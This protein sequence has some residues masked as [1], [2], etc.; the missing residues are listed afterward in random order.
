MDAERGDRKTLLSAWAALT[1][2]NSPNAK[3]LLAAMT[4]SSAAVSWRGK[5]VMRP[6]AVG[7]SLH[8]RASPPTAS[9][10][11]RRRVFTMPP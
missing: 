3:L 9:S 7:E 5:W 8:A 1:S 10:H 11:G 6:G 2:R 4:P